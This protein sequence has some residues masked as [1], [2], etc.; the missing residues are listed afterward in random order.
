MTLYRTTAEALSGHEEMLVKHLAEQMTIT[1]GRSPAPGERHSWSRS[2]PALRADLISAGL[3]SVEMLIE[4]QLPLTS[5]R[6][7]VVLV[8]RHPRTGGPSYVIVELKQW[9]RAVSFEGDPNLVLIEAYGHRPVTHPVLQVRDYREYLVDFTTVLADQADAVAGVAYL[10][11]ATNS[12]VSDL[13]QL[14]GDDRGRLF[15]GQDRGAFVEYLK[16]R[17]DAESGATYADELLHSRIAPSRQLLTVAAEEVQRREMF[18]LLDEQRDAYNFV[19]HAVERA[20]RENSKTA[21]IVTGGPGSGKSVIALS[22]LGELSRQGRTVLHATGSRSFTQTLRKV[23]G[24]RSTSV[25]KMFQYFNS[26]MAA[27]PNDLDVLILDE[28]HR[29]RETSANR[30]TKAQFRTG[31]P[32]LDELFSAARVPVFLLDEHQ[33]VRPGEQGTVEDIEKY[34]AERG[35]QVQRISLEDQFRCGGSAAY[36]DWVQRLLELTPGGP[37][38][39]EGDERFDVEVVDSPNELEQVMQA[40]RDAGFGARLSAGYCWPWS[41]PRPDGSLVNDVVIGDWSHPWNLKGDR[42]IGGA[43]PAALWA[44]DDAGFG[45]V[46]CVYTA[47]GFE[48]DY[49]GVI[50]GPDMVIRGGRWVTDRSKNRDPDFKNTKKVSDQDFDRL[51]RNVYKVLL[52]RGMQGVAIYSPDEETRES[53][54]SLITTRSRTERSA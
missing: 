45:Q 46:G 29:V 3:G 15:T 22:L 2:I 28:A 24:A 51:V 33:V 50:I 12:E 18:T 37:I 48:Y 53:L 14:P 23:A 31:R 4:Y 20:R 19:L 30:W 9:S 21:V 47:Q 7:D 16:S 34:A 38:A 1:T 32:Q 17:F 13:L 43:P 44:S 36:V 54:R 27:E 10:H 8:G 11:N 26:F 6:A 40:H 52:T 42:A 41:D 25:K 35:I 39:W 5:K 49:A